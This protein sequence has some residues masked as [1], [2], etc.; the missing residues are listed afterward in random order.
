M[1]NSELNREFDLLYNNALSGGGA[2]LNTYEKSLFL[3]E[4]QEIVVKG[5]YEDLRNNKSV[6][7]SERIRRRLQ[8]L[9]RQGV[10]LFD[11]ELNTVLNALK[12]STDSKIFEISIDTW[13][14]LVEEVI[15]STNKTLK[16]FPT[17]TDEYLI[18]KDNPFKR[19]NSRK[20]WRLDVGNSI[21]AGS[22]IVEILSTSLLDSYKYRYVAKPE[23]IILEDL[24]SGEYTGLGLTIDSVT[25]ETEC[26]LD[27]EVQRDILV[28][29]VE[30]AT[31]AYKE[32]T[33]S[34]NVQL[35]NSNNF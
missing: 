4:A 30:L 11:S 16:V 13:Y 1:I 23:P 14:I 27:S 34:N 24:T 31:L 9:I 29:A 2:P 33:L 12:I 19:P 32:N 6:E 22:K 17:T 7:A 10:T 3:T 21:V 18:Q 25:T 28:K 8:P 5:L 35:N 20:A 26:K 15:T